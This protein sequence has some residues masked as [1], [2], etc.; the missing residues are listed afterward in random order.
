MAGRHWI[1]VGGGSE[2]GEL[3]IG[4]PSWV[5]GQ[6]LELTIPGLDAGGHWA[7]L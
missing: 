2:K 6:H 3:S 5:Q 1:D 7:S 4:L